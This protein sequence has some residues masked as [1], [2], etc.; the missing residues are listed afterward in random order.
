MTIFAGLL[1]SVLLVSLLISNLRRSRVVEKEAVI[2]LYFFERKKVLGKMQIAENT[3]A[4]ASPRRRPSEIV[5][6]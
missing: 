3:T 4:R 6:N 5:K 1:F 2:V